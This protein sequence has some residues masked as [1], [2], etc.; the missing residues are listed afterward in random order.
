MVAALH[1]L[2]ATASVAADSSLVVLDKNAA[3]YLREHVYHC[4]SG[5]ANDLEVIISYEQIMRSCCEGNW[6]LNQRRHHQ[7]CGQ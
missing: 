6:Q 1:S 4:D 5:T 3:I 2:I 7:G